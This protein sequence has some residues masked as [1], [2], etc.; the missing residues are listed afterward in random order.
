MYNKYEIIYNYEDDTL[1][2]FKT[3][4]R[5][6]VKINTVKY[7]IEFHTDINGNTVNDI[8]VNAVLDDNV[9]LLLTD[10]KSN[11]KVIK[12]VKSSYKFKY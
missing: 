9:E 8:Y 2:I 3:P 11:G 6:P 1:E 5:N 4:S 10:V 12:D 7:G